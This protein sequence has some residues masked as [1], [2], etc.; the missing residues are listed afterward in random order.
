MND[1]VR[2]VYSAY[3]RAAHASRYGA[4]TP[5]VAAAKL[6]RARAGRGSLY[7]SPRSAFQTSGQCPGK[8][9]LQ[10]LVAPVAQRWIRYRAQPFG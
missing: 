2:R 10:F 5:F 1:L 3:L 8:A 4:T 9:I 7:H 6:E